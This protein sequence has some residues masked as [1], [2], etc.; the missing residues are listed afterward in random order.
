MRRP[1]HEIGI[2]KCSPWGIVT[3]RSTILSFGGGSVAYVPDS[4]YE[5]FQQAGLEHWSVRTATGST[6]MHER[7]W[8]LPRPRGTAGIASVQAVLVGDI[9]WRPSLV[10]AR[11]VDRTTGDPVTGEEA[12]PYAELVHELPRLWRESWIWV[13]DPQHETVVKH[14]PGTLC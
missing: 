8:R 9:N 1:G 14:P 10:E 7:E 3:H 13:W 6:W 12:S 2:G 5:Q 4:V 11:W